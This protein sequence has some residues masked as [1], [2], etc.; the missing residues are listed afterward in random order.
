MKWLAR[1]INQWLRN[2]RENDKIQLTE[3]MPPTSSYDT[4]FGKSMHII[5]YNAEGGKIVK[6]HYDDYVDDY[7][8]P[9]P[10]GQ[11]RRKDSV[12]IIH[13]DDN[14]TEIL[15]KLIVLEYMQNG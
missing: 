10:K 3:P 6:F 15:S 9:S 13:E 4:Q 5:V 14:F 1:K 7:N 11:T 2:A 8:S 12:H